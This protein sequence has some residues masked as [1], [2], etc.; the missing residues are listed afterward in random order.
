MSK[1]VGEKYKCGQKNIK[2][3]WPN[4]RK[5]QKIYIR[6]GL[7]LRFSFGDYVTASIY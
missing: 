2:N 3:I 4:M 5:K 6:V 1:N 7:Y